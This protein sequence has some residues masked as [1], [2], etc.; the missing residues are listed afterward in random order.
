MIQSEVARSAAE[1]KLAQ[2]AE[3]DER[4]GMNSRR[5]RSRDDKMAAARENSKFKN[6]LIL[7]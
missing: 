4:A 3:G 7:N 6:D 1:R 5:A 2:A